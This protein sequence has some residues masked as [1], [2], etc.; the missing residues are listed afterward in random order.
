MES[1][2]KNQ[3]YYFKSQSL[4]LEKARKEKHI[5]NGVFHNYLAIS[6]QNF[7][8]SYSLTEGLSFKTKISDSLNNFWNF[9]VFGVPPRFLDTQCADGESNKIVSEKKTT[10]TA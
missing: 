7:H 4:S 9:D 1:L 3:F 8:S 6:K 5:K 10:V 2:R